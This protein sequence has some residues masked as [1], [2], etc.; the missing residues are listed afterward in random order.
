M[1]RVGSGPLLMAASVEKKNSKSKVANVLLPPTRAAQVS[2]DTVIAAVHTGMRLAVREFERWTDGESLADWG[3]EPVLT[4]SCARAICRAARASG[5]LTSI[6]LEQ[7]FASLLA[8]SARRHHSG[9]P[10]ETARRLI[11]QPN[12]RIDLVLWNGNGTPRA[13]VEVKRSDTVSGLVSDAE[14]LTDF[15]RYAGRSY[16]GTL[17]YGLLATLVQHPTSSSP[18][19]RTQKILRRYDALA[20]LARARGFRLRVHGPHPAPFE[21]RHHRCD[22]ETVVFEFA[23]APNS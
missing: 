9:R 14:R 6:T 17:R 7:S 3:V 4:A 18:P 2:R 16:E 13:I 8:W 10:P 19:A 20:E 21:G 5:G 12:K 15:V 1:A 11:D 22:V 23:L